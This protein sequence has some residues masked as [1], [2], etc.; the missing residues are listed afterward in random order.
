[1]EDFTVTVDDHFMGQALTVA[2]QMR[3]QLEEDAHLEVQDMFID[4]KTGYLC[5]IVRKKKETIN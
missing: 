4:D 5:V 2:M 3:E 1:M